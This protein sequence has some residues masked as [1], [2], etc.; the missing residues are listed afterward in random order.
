M[1]HGV[2]FVALGKKNPIF[3]SNPLLPYFL[4][5]PRFY[6]FYSILSSTL[7]LPMGTREADESAGDP[8]SPASKW[9][10]VLFSGFNLLVPNSTPRAWHFSSPSPSHSLLPSRQLNHSTPPI[11]QNGWPSFQDD[12]E[13]LRHEGNAH[14]DVGSRCCWKDK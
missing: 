1:N 13:D 5:L 6:I 12:G 7:Y 14:P 11:R 8:F 9:N 3:I 10:F 4:L 2:I